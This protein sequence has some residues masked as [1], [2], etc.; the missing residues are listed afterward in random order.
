MPKFHLPV[1]RE[2]LLKPPGQK[3]AI[4]DSV[5]VIKKKWKHFRHEP[6]EIWIVEGSYAQACRSHGGSDHK[7]EDISTYSLVRPET[8]ST[9]AWVD[10]DELELVTEGLA[11]DDEADRRFGQPH[12]GHEEGS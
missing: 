5:R 8:G 7:H 10:E 9:I 12:F 6:G 11:T 3:F 4:G 2:T 1:T